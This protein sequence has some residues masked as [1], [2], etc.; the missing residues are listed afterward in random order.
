MKNKWAVSIL[1]KDGELIMAG[2]PKLIILSERLRGKS[3]ELDKDVMSAGR[4]EQR[5]IC[6]KDTTLSSHHCDFIKQG[7]K[8][9]LRDNNST[10]G[11]RVNNNPVTTEDYELN[12]SD[13]VQLGG[14]EMLYDCGAGLNSTVTRTHTGIDLDSTE[15]NLGSVRDLGNFS[16]F[17][18]NDGKMSK[19]I[20][21]VIFGLII[22]L[23]L[24][25]VVGLAAVIWKIVSQSN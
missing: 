18:K 17:A 14:V 4:N 16:P 6:I 1:A 9:I 7:D 23:A 15:V 8:Y 25:V 11:T 21:N 24:T 22:L 5:D 19:V 13:I 12:N 10:N 3:F 2:N 20:Q